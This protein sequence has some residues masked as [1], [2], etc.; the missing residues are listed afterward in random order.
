MEREEPKPE[1][2]ERP[3]IDPVGYTGLDPLVAHV[4]L[5]SRERQHA[6]ERARAER[7]KAASV[8]ATFPT[9]DE[10]IGTQTGRQ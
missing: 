4:L 5:Y 9:A 2:I 6:K 3:Y 7:E 8:A 10:L 1:L